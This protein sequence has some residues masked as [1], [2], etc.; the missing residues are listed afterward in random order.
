M[1]SVDLTYG[2]FAE[3]KYVDCRLFTLEGECEQHLANESQA[4]KEKVY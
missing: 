1:E 2:K 4:L 3:K